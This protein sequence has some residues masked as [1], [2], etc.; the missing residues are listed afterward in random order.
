MKLMREGRVDFRCS[1]RAVALF[2]VVESGWRTAAAEAR[3]E[4]GELFG[5]CDDLRVSERMIGVFERQDAHD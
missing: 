3:S 4:G 5:R 1:D 2:R